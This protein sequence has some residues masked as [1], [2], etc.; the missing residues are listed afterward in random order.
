MHPRTF[1]LDFAGVI[2][3]WP[4]ITD[5]QRVAAAAGVRPAALEQAY[6]RARPDYERGG[7][8]VSFWE[9][10]TGLD[11][12]GRDDDLFE[13]L[14]AA[15]TAAWCHFNQ[16][17]VAVLRVA[18]LRPCRLVLAGNAP[19]EVAQSIRRSTIGDVFDAFSFSCDTG[20]LKPDPK[21]FQLAL[22]TAACH[23]QS[24]VFIDESAQAATVAAEQG[25]N[26]FTFS[27]ARRLDDQLSRWTR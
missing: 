13:V 6:W 12:L 5:V 27:T 1:I 2:T 14:A 23:S 26:A 18:K 17:V 8:A 22:D 9:E 21:T 7:S 25:L 4:D 19:H 16:D 15:D 3:H 24:A 10:V 11:L 20:V